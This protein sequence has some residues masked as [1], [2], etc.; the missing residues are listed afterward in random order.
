[1]TNASMTF[2]RPSRLAT[3]RGAVWFANLA[4]ALINSLRR[5]DR[6]QL[7]LQRKEPKNAQE[8]LAMA[9]GLES[10]SPGLA[11]DLRGAAMLDLGR[12]DR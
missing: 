5:L 4:A 10:H 6:W 11:A 8:L 12:E 1:M 3:P 7:S 2:G 9:D